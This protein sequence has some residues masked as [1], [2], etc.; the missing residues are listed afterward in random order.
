VF[1]IDAEHLTLAHPR[2]MVVVASSAIN[3]S[4]V[5]IGAYHRPLGY[6]ATE[7][8]YAGFGTRVHESYHRAESL[9]SMSWM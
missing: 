7:N 4:D 1:R 2:M 3:K 5:M 8:D 6:D 9:Q